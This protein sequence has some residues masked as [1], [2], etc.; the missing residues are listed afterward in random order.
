[1]TKYCGSSQWGNLHLKVS[2]S[3][4]VC[5]NGKYLTRHW[6]SICHLKVEPVGQWCSNLYHKKIVISLVGC[7]KHYATLCG[8]SA[9]YNDLPINEAWSMLYVICSK[10]NLDLECCHSCHTLFPGWIGGQPQPAGLSNSFLAGGMGSVNN[11]QL[12]P[13]YPVENQSF[14]LQ[15]PPPGTKRNKR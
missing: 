5:Y 14:L 10:V 9:L 1:M 3:N 8:V 2:H 11:S 13:S 7:V 4:V 6:P 12:L 15:K